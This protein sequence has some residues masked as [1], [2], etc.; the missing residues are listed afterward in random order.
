MI[1]NEK[2]VLATGVY[3]NADV[4]SQ[5]VEWHLGIGV[6]FIVAYDLGSSD[7]SQDILNKFAKS[8]VLHWSVIPDKNYTRFD[9]FTNIAMV[10]KEHYAADW[11]LNCDPDEFLCAQQNNLREVLRGAN[12]TDTA[13]LAVPRLNMTGPSLAQGQC[14]LERQTL[15]IDRPTALSVDEKVSGNFP[16]PYIF[17]P[18][19]PK[20]IVRASSL[21]QIAAGAHSASS[22]H[23]SQAQADTLR[24][25]HYPV[26]GYSDFETKAR[27]INDWLKRNPELGSRYAFHWQRLVRIYQ[28]GKLRSEYD[29]QFVSE[30]QAGQLMQ[31]GVCAIDEAVAAW[32]KNVH[33]SG[34]D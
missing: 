1:R 8:N 4:L 17:I 12:A 29:A 2:I 10:A 33:S 24:F 34:R 11:V 23:G 15:R 22:S 20:T 28:A 7:G 21:I 30:E 14:P 32:V 9:P 13:V 18:V 16:C 6:D 19:G 31:D 25:L 26:R 3:D 5:F 27:N